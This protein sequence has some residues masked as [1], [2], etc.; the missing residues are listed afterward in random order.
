MALLRSSPRE[1]RPASDLQLPAAEPRK[2]GHLKIF[3]GA[4]PGVG[5]T[6]E[7]LRSAQARR[8]EG[9]DVV[10]GILDTHGRQEMRPL[11]AEFE[12]APRRDAERDRQIVEEFDLD[13]VLTRKPA[14][15]LVDAMAHTNAAGGR[16]G[17]RY[18]DIEALLAT[19]I[20]VYTTLNIEQIESLNDIAARITRIRMRE[21]VPDGVVEAADQVEVVDLT[22]EDLLRRLQEGK[23]H[24][25][26]HAERSLKHYF[27]PGTIDALR[28]LTLRW[29]A[30]RS[31]DRTASLL[32]PQSLSGSLS[33][34]GRVLVC[35][36]E[37]TGCTGLVLYASRLAD[38]LQT[39]WTA[40]YVES[41]IRH[42]DETELDRID[43]C[44]RLASWLGGHTVTIPG[45][46]IAFEI[47]AYA[48]V[49]SV[50]QIVIGKS[51]RSR[52]SEML[53][54]SVVRQVVRNAGKI[55]VHVIAEQGTVE[56]K[57]PEKALRRRTPKSLDP[58]PYLL[59]LALVGISTAFAVSLRHYLDPGSVGTMYVAV[60]L[61]A[62]VGF[63]FLPSLAAAF[64]SLLAYDFFFL[65]PIYSLEIDE[66]RD[67]VVAFFFSMV[68]L[69]TSRLASQTRSQVLIARN[70]ARTTAELYAFSRMLA[71]IASIDE[72][73]W[74]TAQQVAVMLRSR[75][76]ILLCSPETGVTDTELTLRAAYPPDEQLGATDLTA[77]L[78][79]RNNNRPA[80]HGTDTLPATEWSFLPLRTA[81][82][83]V[84]V[85]AIRRDGPDTLLTPDERRLLNALADQAG[86]AIDRI[87]LAAEIDETRI[88]HETERLRSAL[89][90]S[91]SHD[92]RTPL[93]AVLGA[94]SS[95]RN[96]EGRL[97]A[98]GRDELLSTAQ[99]E[100]ERLNRFV[101]NLL[102]ITRL[103]S[104]ALDITRDPVD[105]ADILGSAVRRAAKILDGR[106]V[107]IKIEPELPMLRLDFVLFEQVC[108]NLLDNAAKYSPPGSTITL[109]ATRS[110]G[111][112]IL[113]IA[114]E[115]VGI[116]AADL[117][118]I[119]DKFYRVK[120]RDRQQA[121][122]GL[123]LAICRGFVETQG[124]TIRAGNRTDRQG[125]I[126]T[127]TLPIEDDNWAEAA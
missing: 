44:L 93:A 105:L 109:T 51:Q 88:L 92:L 97:D 78:W 98:A 87:S 117:E 103:E 79:A 121:G 81:R 83:T 9:V 41:T 70:R 85:L 67:T 6:F 16:H 61:I 73:L 111:F 43:D 84:G 126:F 122:T 29:A 62:A 68:A 46:D 19:G 95:L 69:I 86:V 11:V 106:K 71:G 18:G 94:L 64:F 14:L 38:Q 17:K 33:G 25:P 50:M 108:F 32:K 76:A 116:P 5:K 13:A 3:L 37:H 56:T 90:A 104:G 57:P 1:S 113:Q 55:S 48:T 40:L 66:P 115:G 125:A 107:K 99:E 7:M 110:D 119:F 80:G 4:M 118:R 28:R 89:L 12:Q 124:G 2:T 100:A 35:I 91:I 60:V 23:V 26:P 120:A 127:I 123:G 65:P 47:L 82:H 58:L 22:A 8:R 114:D 31:G 112:V 75:V 59:G 72:L 36:N 63:G 30:E 20:D 54:G 39:R 102:D 10:I 24:I 53:H 96:Y 34:K 74:A 15:V 52:W 27:S 42:P 45:G 49:N 21:T 101:N 77:A